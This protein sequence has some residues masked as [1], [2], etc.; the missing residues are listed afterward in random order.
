MPSSSRPA[1]RHQRR[2]PSDFSGRNPDAHSADSKWPEHGH[3]GRSS[4]K[5]G[6]F[7]LSLGID[8]LKPHGVNDSRSEIGEETEEK[9]TRTNLED[10]ANTN[11]EVGMAKSKLEDGPSF[12]SPMKTSEDCKERRIKVKITPF[13]APTRI[14]NGA[15]NS[16]SSFSRRKPKDDISIEAI[17]EVTRL[18]RKLN[19][20]KRLCSACAKLVLQEII[21][22]PS[23]PRLAWGRKACRTNQPYPLEKWIPK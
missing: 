5:T 16:R 13:S 2:I 21:K 3:S 15:T 6:G 10:Q 12:T 18:L 22:P 9:S 23:S 1:E 17:K 20:E 8:A 7:E 11:I 4:R 19:N 14:L